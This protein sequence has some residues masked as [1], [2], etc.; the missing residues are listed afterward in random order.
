MVV[1]TRAP[2]RAPEPP[3]GERHAW[4]LGPAW[5]LYLS[6]SM[7]LVAV[8][9][10]LSQPG[11]RGW[12]GAALLGVV[13]ALYLSY[14]RSLYLQDRYGTPITGVFALTVAALVTVAVHFAPILTFCLFVVAPMCFMTAGAVYGT[15]SVGMILLLPTLTG[16]WR[17]DVDTLDA[18][19]VTGIHLVIIGFS[20][21]FG[22]WFEKV[23]EESY[24]RAELIRELRESRAEAA[25][26][27]EEGGALAERER[28]ARELHDTLAQGFT[29]IIT[30][31]QAV[32]SELDTDPALARRHLALMRETAAENLDE[33][34]AMVAA[35]RPGPLGEDTLEAVL[36]R[37]GAR[38]GTELG[39]PVTVEVLG[40]PRELPG[41][42]QVCLLRTAQEALA[43]IRKHADAD[44]VR[45][46]LAHSD[47]GTLLTVTDDG[48]GFDPTV[49]G[50]GNGLPGMRHR[51][52]SVEGSL[53]IDTAP[54][55]GTTVRLALP[56]PEEVAP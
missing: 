5:Y 50:T 35:R 11:V 41:D 30:L 48:R 56:E 27:S 18:L 7:V 47:A 44:R 29:S 49:P 4:D 34:R 36:H 2:E 31:T 37:I 19:V 16:W 15:A 45:L 10:V 38:L 1:A 3:G 52:Q 24:E 6:G 13:A 12:A 22:R 21:W 51:A 55:R 9:G 14:G 17:G 53:E 26:L 28:L 46:T 8:I 42:L 40:G 43:N 32:E 20:L 33:A 54:G 23:V 39:I 25:R